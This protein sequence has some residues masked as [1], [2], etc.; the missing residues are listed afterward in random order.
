[1]TDDDKKKNYRGHDRWL[2]RRGRWDNT[3][4]HITRYSQVFPYVQSYSKS[5]V[6][7]YPSFSLHAVQKVQSVS[8]FFLYPRKKQISYLQSE[9]RLL[10]IVKD[11]HWLGNYKL[12]CIIIPWNAG[13]RHGPKKARRYESVF[14][15]FS[16]LNTQVKNSLKT[17]KVPMQCCICYTAT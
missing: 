9:K 6:H 7:N 1:M 12:V 3:S 11:K 14:P 17:L 2:K 8:L 15:P 13:V 16:S 5:N 10:N 4:P